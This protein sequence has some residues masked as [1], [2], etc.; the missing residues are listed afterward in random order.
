MDMLDQAFQINAWSNHY[1]CAKPGANT[2]IIY[3]ISVQFCQSLEALRHRAQVLLS[4]LY[5]A[6]LHLV[7][8]CHQPVEQE[9]VKSYA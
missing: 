9:S 8:I 4:A 5:I 3:P 6:Y 7:I 2:L 1:S